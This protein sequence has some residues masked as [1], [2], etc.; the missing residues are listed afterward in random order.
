MER[1]IE[2]RAKGEPQLAMQLRDEITSVIGESLTNIVP[3]SPQA[4]SLKEELKK[5]GIWSQY[6]EVGIGPNAEVFTKSQPFSSVGFGAEVGVLSDSKWNNPEPEVVLVVNNSG[7][8]LGGTLGNDV[9][10]RGYEGRSA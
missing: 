7:K 5:R 3:G 9:N 2:E 8:I 6:L 4:A 1:V 10:L